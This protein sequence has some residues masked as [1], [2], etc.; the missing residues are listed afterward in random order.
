[1][2]N[3]LINENEK[4]EILRKHE[5]LKKSL[6]ETVSNRIKNVSNFRETLSEQADPIFIDNRTA[7]QVK[8]DCVTDPSV[9]ANLYVFKGKPAIKVNGG[10]D[11]IRIYTNEPNQNF[12]GYNYYVLN[13]AETKILKGPFK[14]SCPANPKVD[15]N[16]VDMKTDFAREVATGNWKDR[17]DINIPD[18]ELA[19]TYEQHPKHKSLWKKKAAVNKVSGFE[20]DQQSFIN[21]WTAS[22]EDTKTKFATEA[23]KINPGASDFATGQWTRNNYFI[24]PGSE[25]YFPA[26]EKGQKGLK[27]FINAAKLSKE[28]NRENCRAA[29]K[30]FVNM[31]KQSRGGLEPNAQVF[32]DTKALVKLCKATMKFGGPFSK[33]DDDLNFLAGQTVDGYKGPT[34][35]DSQGIENKWRIN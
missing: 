2:K 12:G 22:T 25:V 18:S 1:M 29:I 9:K 14:W 26:D 24:A 3:F 27:I 23:Y 8:K 31:Y 35:L 5:D 11:N 20:P 10:P 19:Q 21:A 7:E 33:V 13:T 15:Q 32:A 17:K 34:A 30:T 6:T 28:P 16:A 4:N